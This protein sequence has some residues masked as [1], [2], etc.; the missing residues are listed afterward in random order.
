ME[1]GARRWTSLGPKYL[2]LLYAGSI[3]P[4]V[5]QTDR[6][7]APA[8]V[9]ACSLIAADNRLN[10]PHEKRMLVH[11]WPSKHD[12]GDV[13]AFLLLGLHDVKP[14]SPTNSS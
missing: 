7:S 4:A 8:A 10:L 11:F 3:L 6:K 2:K 14:I 13:V 12:G 5:Q 1:K 9:L